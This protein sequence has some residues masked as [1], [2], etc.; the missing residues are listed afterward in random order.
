MQILKIKEEI[1]LAK[2]Y[3]LYLNKKLGNGGFGEIYKG[4]EIRT[5]KKIA[6]KCETVQPNKTSI[7]KSEIEILRY[8]RGIQ[9]IPKIYLYIFSKN[10]NFLLFELLGKNIDELFKL[11]HKSFSLTTV[12]SLGLQ[13]LNRIEAIHSLHIIHRDI[14]P[15]N[16]LIGKN[17]K[18]S[19][20]YLC[21][22]GLAKRF[23]D[24]KTGDH[25]PY[26]EKK[27]FVGTPTFASV[28]A[29]LGCE[30]SRRDDL[31]SL[32]YILIYLGTGTLPWKGIKSKIKDEKYSKILSLKMNLNSEELLKGLPS[33]LMAFLQNVRDLQFDQKPD[34]NY[35]RGL[36][37][38]MNTSKVP[39][40]KLKMDY[41][42]LLEKN[43]IINS[44]INKNDIVNKH[45][46]NNGESKKFTESN[47]NN[48]SYNNNNI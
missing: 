13:M 46:L 9:G 18:I 38:K 48:E 11:C 16:F 40:E 27:H 4:E 42:Y 26:S 34:Y 19:S 29:H 10:Y 22:F 2:N 45:L 36:L 44:N 41:I 8:L 21:D 15:E 43:H 17:D 24:Q 25:I 32:A 23:R 39:L 33:E 30:Q 5:H 6:I 3:K 47:T 35:L 37:R 7:L 31:E 12:L 20:V 14:K 28:Y 1:T